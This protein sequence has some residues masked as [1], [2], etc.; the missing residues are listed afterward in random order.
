ML[1]GLNF[2][3]CFDPVPHRG[4]AAYAADLYAIAGRSSGEPV[5]N[6]E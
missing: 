3:G 4:G 6:F 5:G 1:E 2:R